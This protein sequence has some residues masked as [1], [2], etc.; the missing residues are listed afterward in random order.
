MHVRTASTSLYDAK[1][2]LLFG[3]E[4]IDPTFAVINTAINKTLDGSVKPSTVPAAPV[5]QQQTTTTSK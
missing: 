5:T 4:L 3:K 2:S 1:N